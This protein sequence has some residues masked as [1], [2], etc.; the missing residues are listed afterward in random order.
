LE[1]LDGVQKAEV[2]LQTQEATV[3]YLPDK[4]T[5]EKMIET[6]AATPHMMGVDMHYRAALKQQ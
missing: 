1:R 2:N 6:V 5:V 3:S 4:V